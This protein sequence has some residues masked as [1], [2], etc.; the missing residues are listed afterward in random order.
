MAQTL[1]ELLVTFSNN[2]LMKDSQI[3]AKDKSALWIDLAKI[4]KN[5]QNP[6][7][8]KMQERID[9]TYRTLIQIL[10]YVF[11]DLSAK[12]FAHEIEYRI[13]QYNKELAFEDVEQR[14]WDIAGELNSD[15]H[16]CTTM[17]RYVLMAY[18]L[19]PKADL[20]NFYNDLLTQFNSFNNAFPLYP[21][22]IIPEP[23]SQNKQKPTYR[24]TSETKQEQLH[25]FY[26]RTFKSIKAHPKYE[27]LVKGFC[28]YTEV[29]ALHEV[30][31][32]TEEE[33]IAFI[34][35]SG[36]QELTKAYR[37]LLEKYL[38]RLAEANLRYYDLTQYL[39]NNNRTL[40]DNEVNFIKFLFSLYEKYLKQPNKIDLRDS[41]NRQNWKIITPEERKKLIGY[42]KRL[43]DNQLS[44]LK[45]VG[46][47]LKES[48]EDRYHRL[49]AN[50][51]DNYFYETEYLAK[52]VWKTCTRMSN[53]ATNHLD[54]GYRT[55]AEH[56]QIAYEECLKI[57]PKPKHITQTQYEEKI[58]KALE[59]G[60]SQSKQEKDELDLLTDSWSFLTPNKKK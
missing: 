50:L 26:A 38:N 39:R 27:I 4:E 20:S 15:M 28:A 30:A 46:G 60:S 22:Q 43:N 23:T 44:Y 14:Y 52:Y 49:I 17:Y 55:I 34:S 18:A 59:N 1:L 13:T 37:K 53:Y 24:K 31:G 57:S 7:M 58:N 6:N 42:L 29:D 5:I 3:E 32:Y 2:D 21:Y 40:T 25:G 41:R 36:F 16:R 56:I 10:N 35:N 54:E 11:K 8:L 9:Q 47:F 12:S 33:A 48:Y 19:D 45:Y 51:N